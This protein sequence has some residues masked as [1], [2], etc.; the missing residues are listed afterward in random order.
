[1]LAEHVLKSPIPRQKVKWFTLKVVSFLRTFS[2][3]KVLIIN[4]LLVCICCL[5]NTVSYGWFKKLVLSQPFRCKIKK[6]SRPN[7]PSVTLV[8]RT[9]TFWV[10]GGRMR[11]GRNQKS[12][13]ENPGFGL[14]RRMPSSSTAVSEHAK[15]E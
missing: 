3:Q 14:I 9:R 7:Q 15:R 10:G 5:C 4:I 13:P 2:L 6:Q 1:M 8:P 11:S 12:E